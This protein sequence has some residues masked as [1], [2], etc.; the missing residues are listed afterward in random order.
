METSKRQRAFG[1]IYILIATVVWGSS[2]FILKNTLDE[3]SVFFVFGFRFSI[4]AVIMLL[5]GIKHIREIDRN[6]VKWGIIIGANLF[7]AYMFQTYGLMYTTPGKNAFLSATY[8]VIVP[9]LMCIF[10]RKKP[11]AKSFVAAG[12]CIA[13]IGL[14]SLEGD[15]SMGIGDV[16][17]LICGFFFALHIIFLSK[18]AGQCNSFILTMIM[19]AVVGG[20]SWAGFAATGSIAEIEGLSSDGWISMIYMTL[21]CTALAYFLQTVGQKYTPPSQTAILLTFEAVFGAVFSAVFYSEVF[22]A[23]VVAGFLLVFIAVIISETDSRSL[24]KKRAY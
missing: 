3:V 14:I 17:T 11:E 10:F 18:S 8:C 23:K 19:F 21:C 1:R 12:I 16:L 5:L 7:V 22:T 24:E 13:G 6:T 9:F 15:M 2:F 4:A 20:L